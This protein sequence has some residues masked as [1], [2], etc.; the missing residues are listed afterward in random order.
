MLRHSHHDVTDEVRVEVS[1]IQSPL[2]REP[3]ELG[4]A[5]IGEEAGVFV[6]DEDV[7]TW[8][9]TRAV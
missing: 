3:A 2:N 9:S 8:E 7:R 5:I 4:R 1:L 6:I